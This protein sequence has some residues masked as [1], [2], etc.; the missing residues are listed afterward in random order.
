MLEK[1]IPFIRGKNK[2]PR[3]HTRTVIVHF[4][5]KAFYVI[6]F[7]LHKRKIYDERR[8]H[9]TNSRIH[10]TYFQIVNKS[11][12][13]VSSKRQTNV[14]AIFLV[15][16]RFSFPFYFCQGIMQISK[17]ILQ[18]QMRWLINWIAHVHA[19][20]CFRFYAE[21]ICICVIR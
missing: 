12:F 7:W 6:L 21:H 10:F 2:N 11:D 8:G 17:V 4:I 9:T 15:R 3:A 5:S 19:C 14:H 20:T 1:C 18:M 13:S 16:L